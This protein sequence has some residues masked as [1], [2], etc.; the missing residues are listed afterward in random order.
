VTLALV[1]VLVVLLAVVAFAVVRNRPGNRSGAG[2]AGVGM[3]IPVPAGWDEVAGKNGQMMAQVSGDLAQDI[4]TGPRIQVRSSDLYATPSVWASGALSNADPGAISL[5]EGPS[6]V[7]VGAPPIQGT[8][9]TIQEMVG[10]RS[11]TTRQII[12]P[13]GGGRSVA[14]IFAGPTEQFDSYQPVFAA[15]LKAAVLTR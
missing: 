8:S 15:A 1:G 14:I 6:R 3:H 11:I 2:S 7:W 9:V 5:G 13:L 10:G 12:V 4:P